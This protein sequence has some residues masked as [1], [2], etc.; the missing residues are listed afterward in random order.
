MRTST[1]QG[2]I[3]LPRPKYMQLIILV[4]W[5]DR[6]LTCRLSP[7]TVRGDRAAPNHRSAADLLDALGAK[8]RAWRPSGLRRRS[9][10]GGWPQ[11]YPASLRALPSAMRI[12]AR[13]PSSIV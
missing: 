12:A 2:V 6:A 8:E 3:P 7:H 4:E 5:G 1:V 13:K 11:T 9:Q 10:G